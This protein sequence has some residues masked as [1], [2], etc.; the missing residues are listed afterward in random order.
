MDKKK[1]HL[2]CGEKYL[3][4]YINI[5]YSQKE[6]TV[7]SIRADIYQDI[8]TLKYKENSIDEIRSHH[9][10]EH[11]SR[12]DALKFLM[13]W[14][15]WLKTGGKLVIETPD[16]RA[17]SSAYLRAATQKRRMEIGRHVFGSHEASWAYHYDFWDELKFRFVLGRTGFKNIKFEKY[18]NSLARYYPRVPFVNFIGSILPEAFYKKYGGNKLPNI[19]AKAEKDSREINEEVVVK[20]ILSQYLVGKEDDKILNVWLEQYYSA[21]NKEE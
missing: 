12:V 3:D 9:L 21:G 4:G 5:D 18:R 8:K 1:L 11:F 14:Q 13:T 16:Y 17:C 19:L 7:M 20:E 6:H 15:K 2:G 10:F